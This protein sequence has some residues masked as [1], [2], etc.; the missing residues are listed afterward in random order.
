MSVRS[1]A[2]GSPLWNAVSASSAFGVFVQSI[3]D[4]TGDRRPDVIA[5][6]PGWN[7]PGSVTVYRGD[8]GAVVWTVPAEGF[9]LAGDVDHDGLP[10]VEVV[11]FSFMADNISFAA[12]SGRDGRRIW[13]SRVALPELGGEGGVSIE[14]LPGG[15]LDGDRL[16]DVLVRFAVSGRYP[17]NRQVVVRGRDGKQRTFSTLFGQPL[18]AP[19]GTATDVLVDAE[20]RRNQLTVTNRT[21]THQI[22]RRRIPAAGAKRVFFIDHGRLGLSPSGE[23]LLL[24]SYGAS[25]G[26]VFVMDGRRGVL[27]WTIHVD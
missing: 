19:L 20:V 10:D 3:A 9:V 2:T 16:E 18:Y 8:T 22:W 27:R 24:S 6:A 7:G 5:A 15:D 23:D 26:D 17:L 14:A 4:V 25:G 11:S 21:L 12:L 1:A 13:Q